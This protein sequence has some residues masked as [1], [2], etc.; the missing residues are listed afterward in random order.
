[1]K[2]TRKGWARIYVDKPENV[3]IVKRIIERE[4][5]FEYEYLPSDLVAPFSEYPRLAY[6]HKFCD[7]D[8][9]KITAICWRFGIYIWAC[10]NGDEEYMKDETAKLNETHP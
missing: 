8:M 7:L 2:L 6:T 3:E 10:D 9:N 1:M 4:D 5:A